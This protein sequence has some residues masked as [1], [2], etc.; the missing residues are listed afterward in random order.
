MSAG[1]REP[2][3]AGRPHMPGYGTEQG[4]A[5][6]LPWSWA[7][8]KLRATMNYWVATVRPDGRPHVMPVWAAWDGEALWFGSTHTSRKMRN[9]RADP[10]CTVT[11]DDALDPVVLDGVAD[12]VTD[13]EA[14]ATFVETA[15]AKYASAY[16]YDPDVNA[17]VAIRPAWAFGMR[18]EDFTGTPT[19]WQW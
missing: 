8:D 11:I 12:F 17:V 7:D 2:L 3:N 6:L 5:G 10:R 18:A 19:R 13:P 14:I 16:S 9:L 1:T 4:E 15:N